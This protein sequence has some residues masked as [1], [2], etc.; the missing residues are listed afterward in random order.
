MIILYSEAQM[1]LKFSNETSMEVLPNSFIL[2]IINLLASLS[3]SII[4]GA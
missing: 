3:D 1:E 2:Q 4:Y